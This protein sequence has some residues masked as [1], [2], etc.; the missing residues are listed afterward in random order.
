[1]WREGCGLWG[2]VGEGKG[3]GREEDWGRRPWE[4]RG[5]G[6]GRRSTVNTLVEELIVRRTAFISDIILKY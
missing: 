3:P 1:M 2:P 6:V 4:V 5:M